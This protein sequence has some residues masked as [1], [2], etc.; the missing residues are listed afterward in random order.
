MPDDDAAGAL[1]SAPEPRWCARRAA[2]PSPR[3]GAVWVLWLVALGFAWVM[4]GSRPFTVAADAETA[5]AFVGVIGLALAANVWADRRRL[6]PVGGAGVC[7]DPATGGP[8]VRRGADGSSR[9]A[10]TG[11]VTGACPRAW[12]WV[13]LLAAVL[14]WELVCYFAG[15]DGHRAAFPTISS[16]ETALGHWR[17]GR[18]VM[19][20]AWMALGWRLVRR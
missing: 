7:G 1:R 8:G 16:F 2:E 12:P 10:A 6:L 17:A 4:G 18:A 9:R 20:M 3:R 15:F 5:L 14:V 11:T 13:V 19:V